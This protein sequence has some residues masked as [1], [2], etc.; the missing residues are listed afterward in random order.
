MSEEALP[1]RYPLILNPKAKG[2][3]GRRA[4]KFIMANA[5]RFTIYATRSREE[6]IELSKKFAEDGEDLVIAAGGDGSLNAVIEGLAGSKTALGVFPTGTMNVFAR[7]M[8]IPISKLEGAMEII[9]KGNRESVDLFTMNGAPFVQMAGVGFDAHVIE[10]T[11]WESKKRLGPL[12]YMV[13]T[14]KLLKSKPPLVNIMCDDGREFQGVAMFIGNGALYGGQFPLFRRA[15]NSDQ[16]LDV[17][18]FKESGF[19]FVRDS[20]RGL[21]KGGI[22][23]GS[24]GDSVEYIQASGLTIT[25]EEEVPVEVDGEL[26]GRT[27]EI[28]FASSGNKL[29]VLAPPEVKASRWYALLRSLNPW[30]H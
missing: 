6:A 3:K 8:G 10:Q 25:C 28:E 9:D 22:D 29:K 20:L 15:S 14:A 23:P 27:K 16:L 21:A 12:A 24:P 7:E 2:E 30:T 26:W 1:P 17:V 4:L 13:T 18:I 5:T 19:Q 11:S